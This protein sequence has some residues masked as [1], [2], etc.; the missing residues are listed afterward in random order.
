MTAD[1]VERRFSLR[2]T[3]DAKAHVD[4][5]HRHN[6]IHRLTP[7]VTTLAFDAGVDMR[8]MGKAHEIGQRVHAV[9]LDLERR[10]ACRP[11]TAASPAGFHRRRSRCRGIRRIA[12]P[13]GSPRSRRAARVC[14]TVLAGNFVDSGMHAMAERYRLYDVV[15]RR[16]RPLGKSDTV[17]PEINRTAA[18]GKNIR[19]ICASCGQTAAARGLG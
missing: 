5:M 2:V 11:S 7:A 13:A 15:A 3:V 12:R 19:F 17:T 14:M 10:L 16:P 8:P 1:A 6:S 18:R 4:F 9:P